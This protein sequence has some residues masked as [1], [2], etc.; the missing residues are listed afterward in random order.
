METHAAP[1]PQDSTQSSS[2]NGA[3]GQTSLPQNGDS[4]V[5]AQR[6]HIQHI[7]PELKLEIWEYLVLPPRV[8]RLLL[9]DPNITT[10]HSP[11]RASGE[12][13]IPLI[14]H[15][16]HDSRQFGKSKY[17]VGSSLLAPECSGQDFWD[18]EED[19]VYI[20]K[21]LPDANWPRSLPLR[22]HRHGP[23]PVNEYNFPTAAVNAADIK[24]CYP[25]I[26]EK[27]RHLVLTFDDELASDI[28]HG[29][30]HA[31]SGEG[32]QLLD[33]ICQFKNLDSLTFAIDREWFNYNPE[34]IFLDIADDEEIAAVVGDDAV[35]EDVA[36][37]RFQDV[38][39]AYRAQVDNDWK[40][41]AHIRIREVQFWMDRQ[42]EE[43][44]VGRPF[45]YPEDYFE[46]Y[47]E[48]YPKG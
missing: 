42:G 30:Q 41:P 24:V 18:P 27:T 23:V 38:F 20:P 4:Q 47:H 36:L 7:A 3:P 25:G 8:I 29:V 26:F 45:P 16:C 33:R 34:E 11:V 48:G 43:V 35:D 17:A 22:F 39:E 5:S 40:V 19:I 9:G 37:Q 14:M 31:I 2:Q 21:W 1:Q 44:L 13:H 46:G 6:P 12:R 10:T 32:R 15:I 28:C